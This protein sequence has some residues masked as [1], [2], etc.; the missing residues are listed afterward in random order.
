MARV[1]R[2]ALAEGPVTFRELAALTT[3]L[4]RLVHRGGGGG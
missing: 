4:K 3:G 2:Q 1:G